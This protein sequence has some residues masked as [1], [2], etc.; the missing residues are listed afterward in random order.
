MK[1]NHE[2]EKPLMPVLIYVGLALLALAWRFA[3]IPWDPGGCFYQFWV[4]AAGLAFFAGLYPRLNRV[5][6]VLAWLI[7]LPIAALLFFGSLYFAP[8]ALF[9]FMFLA[10]VLAGALSLWSKGKAVPAA[11]VSFLLVP[12]I[13][14][15]FAGIDHMALL[16]RVRSISPG[17][18][19]EVRLTS[20]SDRGETIV[21][22]K[23]EAITNIVTS[24]RH[25]F[26]Y[27]PNHE[28]IKEPWQLAV[29]LR[30]GS[31]LVLSIGNGNRAH[32]SFVW[33]NFERVAAYQN[34]ELRGALRNSGVNLW[35]KSKSAGP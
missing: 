22:S 3:F 35:S 4:A 18:V 15:C 9:P 30:D 26:P 19:V 33:I 6:R 23:P 17:D 1:G 20:L 5:G 8:Q 25:I 10:F 13:P 16:G 24:L 12:L 31:Q 7:I 28:G 34:A 32:P 11:L 14:Y 27:S 29:L 2:P 21:I